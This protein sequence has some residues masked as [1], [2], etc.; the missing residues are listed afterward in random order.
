MTLAPIP[1]DEDARLE[2]LRELWLLDTEPEER[3]DRVTRMAQRLFDVPIAAFSL[4]DSE[5]VW[6]KSKI[7]L[8]FP[9]MQRG[10][11]F[12]SHAIL[13]DGI[14]QVED[15]AD[16]PRFRH[17]PIVKSAPGVR[18]YAGFPVRSA[19]RR[20]VGVLAIMD[21]KP[22]LLSADD[23]N[24]LADLATGIEGE[25]SAT[26]VSTVDELTGMLNLRG[27]HQFADKLLK[28]SARSGTALSLLYVDVLN[29]KTSSSPRDRETILKQVA[30]TI[31]QTFRQSDVLA[32][33]GPARFCA[34]LPENSDHA[35]ETATA[36]LQTAIRAWNLEPQIPF[37][38][39]VVASGA[40]FDPANPASLEQLMTR[41][42]TSVSAVRAVRQLD[43]SSG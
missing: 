22:R 16:D 11:A 30:D 34:L 26:R 37:K 2:S 43:R 5:R 25:I 29:P 8:D 6:F 41:A 18:F 36:R 28:I 14:I 40:R 15:A 17:S 10:D 1:L 9:E 12:C 21:T 19:E 31:N 32:R 7:G 20:R 35:G 33:I 23:L 39:D 3:F 4:V 24:S 38:L 27:F 42:N 13:T